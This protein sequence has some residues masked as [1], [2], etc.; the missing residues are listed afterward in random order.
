M[1]D[2]EVLEQA[3]R[4]SGAYDRLCDECGDPMIGIM[5]QSG[6]R[7]PRKVCEPCGGDARVWVMSPY[8]DDPAAVRQD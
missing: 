5:V 4:N 3:A 7:T 6:Y 2:R 1:S 8:Q